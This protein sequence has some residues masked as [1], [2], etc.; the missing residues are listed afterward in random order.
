MTLVARFFGAPA[1]LGFLA[2]AVATVWAI[3]QAYA[4]VAQ[5][6]PGDPNIIGFAQHVGNPNAC[7]GSDLCST[8]TGP[9]APGTQGYAE[10]GPSASNP[11]FKLSTITQWFQINPPV[12]GGGSGVSELPGQ[13]VEP[14]GGA[15]NF[16]VINDTG[17]PVP[18]FSLSLNSNLSLAT[19]GQQNDC[20]PGSGVTVPCV[21]FQASAGQN[22]FLTTATLSGPDCHAGCGTNSADFSGGPVIY[23]W[24][25]GNPIP[26]GAEFDINFAS[27]D[28]TAFTTFVAPPL[29]EPATLA[30]LGSA[31]LVFGVARRRKSV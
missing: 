12:A 26:I 5:G 15:G 9:L 24:S 13:P 29:P 17:A 8:N 30:L 10:T 7:G 14:L 31:L 4:L 20:G 18:M 3:P 16:R 1:R 6:A 2:V 11:D 23:T 21:N 27:W 19:A 28:N 22:G 25:G